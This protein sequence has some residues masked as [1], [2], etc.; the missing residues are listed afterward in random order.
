[1]ISKK[2][3]IGVLGGSFDPAHK[4]HVAI[5]NE[6]FKKFKLKKVI[7]LSTDKAVYPI[8]A[9]G[10]SKAMMEKVMIAKSRVAPKG[11]TICATRYGNVIASRGSVI[12]LFIKQ[13]LEGIPITITDPEMT[14]F[15]MSL[16]EAV[17]LVLHAFKNARNGDIF[18]S[19]SPA[20]KI[21][22]IANALIQYLQV[23]KHKIN[24][25]GTRHGEK[26]YEALCSREEMFVAEDQNGFFRIPA[27]N[28]NLNY[29]M[30]FEKGNKEI[31]QISD[32]NSSNTTQ[33][34]E[35]DLIS[36]YKKLRISKDSN[37]S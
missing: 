18:V 6:A 25:I 30:Y 16:E 31:S 14:R 34:S 33:L 9:M 35:D 7:C 37:S 11:T 3:K 19:K 22:N 28:R 17:D 15:M 24:I 13:I 8:N 27:D 23:E 1:M 20:A 5:S 21:G 2:N 10:I 36:I 12:P 29:E 32:Y 4:G 26:A